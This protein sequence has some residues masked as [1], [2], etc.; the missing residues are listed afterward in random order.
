MKKLF[1]LFLIV[2]CNTPM[3]KPNGMLAMDYPLP[4]YQQ[5]PMDCPFSFD[6]KNRVILANNSFCNISNENNFMTK[7][8][9]SNSLIR[10]LMIS[11]LN[12]ENYNT[13]LALK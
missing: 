12:L 11:I 5:A 3:P 10:I 4:V 7:M 1:V 9:H 8:K 2:G 6:F 13:L